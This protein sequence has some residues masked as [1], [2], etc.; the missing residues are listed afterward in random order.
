MKSFRI[1]LRAW[2]NIEYREIVSENICIKEIHHFLHFLLRLIA[3][4]D[5]REA[6]RIAHTVQHTGLAL[7]KR[8]GTALA[9]ALHLAHEENPHTNQ[10]KHR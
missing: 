7:P 9:A 6:D 10:E 2:P 5:I 3:A 4:C 1:L 8:E